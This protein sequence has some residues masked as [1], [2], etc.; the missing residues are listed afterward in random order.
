MVKTRKLA[1]LG[2][3]LTA[4]LSAHD[5]EVE[6]AAVRCVTWRTR[7]FSAVGHPELT[8][9]YARAADD[10]ELQVLSLD[11]IR[12]FSGLFSRAKG[13]APPVAAG[14]TAEYP[15]G[16]FDNAPPPGAAFV[17]AFDV[18]GV[19]QRRHG[20][21]VVLLHA[22]ELAVARAFGLRR[23]LARLA[24]G[25]RHA[26]FPFWWDPDRPTVAREAESSSALEETPRMVVIGSSATLRGD[27]VRVRL[28]PK[29]ARAIAEALAKHGDAPFA[30]LTDA[31]PD[32]DAFLV[33][34]P[35][36]S[37][38]SAAMTRGSRGAAVAGNFVAFSPDAE[39]DRG[40]MLEDG[41]SFELT[42]ERWNEM[43]GA[44]ERGEAFDVAPSGR[45]RGLSIS[46]DEGASDAPPSAHYQGVEV[47]AG[48]HP[49]RNGVDP[50]DLTA[51]VRRVCAAID[52]HFEDSWDATGQDLLVH[53][54]LHPRRAPRADLALRPGPPHA[55]V[56][57]LC[58]AVEAVAPPEVTAPVVFRTMWSLWGGASEG[59][60]APDDR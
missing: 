1:L 34:E 44:M 19:S 53:M 3:E 41:F 47:F 2:E 38:P 9:T 60:V 25:G 54:E 46:W 39:R 4:T 16:L 59:T 32:A 30:W 18:E 29:R 37:T 35:G 10:D 42:R 33:W 55:A 13:G 5:V 26:P 52:R 49:P 27:T 11:A 48:L 56:N 7:G 50:K 36:Q 51:Y 21:A 22:D 57:G 14:M 31:E 8:I 43:R 17:R 40:A 28:P 24:R 58:G 6:G 20:L 23:V 12:F 45:S 15:P